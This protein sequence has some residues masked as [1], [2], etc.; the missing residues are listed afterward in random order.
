MIDDWW[1]M[2]D[3]WWLMI[4]DWWLMIDDWWLMIDDWWLMIDDWCLCC[5]EF[6]EKSIS[7]LV[8]DDDDWWLMID[9]WWLMFMLSGVYGEVDQP[10]GCG[11]WWSGRPCHRGRENQT[12]INPNGESTF[13]R[14]SLWNLP[15]ASRIPFSILEGDESC[16]SVLLCTKSY[17]SHIAMPEYDKRR[18]YM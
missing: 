15:L 1:L 12:E 2:I 8:V 3:D 14:N 6:M 5:Q 9:D 4:D 17:Y 11:W 18:R 10:A 16:R 7:Q 13:L